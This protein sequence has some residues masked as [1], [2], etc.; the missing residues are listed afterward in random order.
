LRVRRRP[1]GLPRSTVFHCY[2]P[3]DI[4][5]AYG[6]DAL[7]AEARPA[8]SDH[9]ARGCVMAVPLQEDLDRFSD[10][11]S[12]PRTTVEISI[13][14]EHPRTTTAVRGAQVGWAVETVWTCSGHMPLHRMLTSFSSP[15]NPAET[16]GVQGFPGMFIASKMALVV[17]PA[18]Y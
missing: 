18:P 6:V 12:L 17:F 16:Q 4:Y 10:T 3:A 1:D 7:H 8:P 9:R 14:T 15:S 11:F 2:T 5:A 13:R